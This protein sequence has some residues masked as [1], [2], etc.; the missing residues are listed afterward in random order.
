M[1]G[2][3]PGIARAEG[4]LRDKAAAKGLLYGCAT[5]S[6]NLA[7]DADFAALVASE[8]GILVHEGELKRHVIESRQGIFN[9]LPADRVKAFADQNGQKLRG[10]T[11]VWFNVNPEWIEP[12]LKDASGQQKDEILGGYITKVVDHYKGQMHSWDVVNEAIEPAD[13]RWDGMRSNSIWYQA[14]GED[15]IRL[16][17]EAAKQADSVA[18]LYLNDYGIE[19]DVRWHELRRT[20]LLHLLD[21][22]KKQN[23]PVEGFGIQGHMHP[24]RER[25]SQERFARFLR[26]LEGYDIDLMITEL[27]VS[28]KDGPEDPAARDAIS[29]SVTRDLLDVALESPRMRGVLTWGLSDRYSWLSGTPGYKRDDGQLS[30]VLPYD[31]D[32]RKKPMWDALAAAFDRAPAR[33]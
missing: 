26:D 14:Y 5:G 3:V 13:W 22:L 4:V 31:G 15:Y 17:F 33:A 11:L 25:F 30:R 1:A 18:K 10:H 28:E 2:L 32:L 19:A 23:V 9:F 8:A 24:G 7:R 6:V 21:R 27:D 12:A 20:A 16:A 29:A